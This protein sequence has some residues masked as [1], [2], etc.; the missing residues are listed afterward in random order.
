MIKH[1]FAVKAAFGEFP[2]E[3]VLGPQRDIT[4]E[5]GPSCVAGLKGGPQSLSIHEVSLGWGTHAIEL[6]RYR[7]QP[8]A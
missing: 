8:S 2:L 4:A 6:G 5:L 3:D 1:D 7:A